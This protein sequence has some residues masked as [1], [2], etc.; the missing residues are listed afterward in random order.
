MKRTQYKFWMPS[1]KTQG[2]RTPSWQSLARCETQEFDAKA[3]VVGTAKEKRS[4]DI[5]AISKEKHLLA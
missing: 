2:K 3:S 4:G 1:T 5:R